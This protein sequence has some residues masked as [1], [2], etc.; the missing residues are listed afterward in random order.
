M[1]SKFFT[2]IDDFELVGFD[3][4][5]LKHGTHDQ[6]THGNWAHGNFSEDTEGENGQSLYFDTYGV[7][8]G[9][10]KEPVGVSRDEIDSLNSYTEDGYKRI[11]GLLRGNLPETFSQD[12]ANMRQL[13]KQRIADLDKL[14]EESPDL[15]SDKNLYRVFTTD[16]L[17]AL[18]EGDSFTDKAFLS[19]TRVDITNPDNVEILQNLQMLTNEVNTQAAVILPS[20]SKS[21]KGLAIDFI[22]NALSD[23]TTNTSTANNEKEVLLPR[24]TSLKFMGYKKINAMTDNVMNVAVFQRMDK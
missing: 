11:N 14:I 13:A 9:A 22:K 15:F 20:P 5:V 16:T 7:T 19:T 21:G 8:T 12:E 17:D 18:K 6:K 24:N 3:S 23:F 10:T 1:V 4:D 2:D